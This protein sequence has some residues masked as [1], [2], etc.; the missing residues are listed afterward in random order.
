[1]AGSRR[2]TD[3]ERRQMPDNGRMASPCATLAVSFDVSQK[4]IYN[5]LNP[6]RSTH[7]ANDRRIWVLTTRATDRGLRGFTPP[8]RTGVSPMRC[9]M[10]AAD[11]ILRSDDAMTG[12]CAP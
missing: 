6:G 10:L 5:A 11:D 12:N 1:M 8:F 4:T 2:L 7:S 9:L 3:Q